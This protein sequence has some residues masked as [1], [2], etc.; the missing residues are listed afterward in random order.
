[1]LSMSYHVTFAL[2]IAENF[3][4]SRMCGPT[5]SSATWRDQI[6]EHLV[7]ISTHLSTNVCGELRMTGQME[8]R[9]HFAW[10][11]S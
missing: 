9:E 1:M 7:A 6:R 5:S 4:C 8:L 3:P 11:F 10:D 2:V